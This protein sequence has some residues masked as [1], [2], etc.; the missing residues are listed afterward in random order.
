MDYFSSDY[1]FVIFE[2]DLFRLHVMAS[3]WMFRFTNP[4]EPSE[5]GGL[6]LRLTTLKSIRV[7]WDS[8]V[9]LRIKTH[10]QVDFI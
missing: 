10:T 9:G 8:V 6:F 1:L 5:I 7:L 2:D 4:C 3:W